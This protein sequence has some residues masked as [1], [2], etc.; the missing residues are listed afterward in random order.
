LID[1][2]GQNIPKG[3]DIETSFYHYSLDLAIEMYLND[4]TSVKA[5]EYNYHYP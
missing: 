5:I 3:F 2:F 1:D 4:K